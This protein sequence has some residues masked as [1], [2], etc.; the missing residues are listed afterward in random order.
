MY[1]ASLLFIFEGDGASLDAAIEENN[2]IMDRQSAESYTCPP[3][4]RSNM[5]L[6]SRMD[7]GIALDA[8][9]DF[10]YEDNDEDDDELR[11]PQIYTLKLIDFAHANF[12]PGQGPDENI[13]LGVRSLLRIFKEMASEDD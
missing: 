8:D 9:D 2:E 13:L 4:S 12:T 11:L 1:S 6:D 5:S 10:D 7:S 3:V